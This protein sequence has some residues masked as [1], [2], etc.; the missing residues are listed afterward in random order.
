VAIKTYFDI[1]DIFDIFKLGVSGDGVVLPAYNP[2]FWLNN[3]G[4]SNMDVASTRTS[5]AT[6]PDHEGVYV[7]CGAGEIMP[8]GG[9][10]EQN[11]L[12]DCRD[13]SAWSGADGDVI[14]NAALSSDG[15]MRADLLAKGVGV[16]AYRYKSLPAQG[17]GLLVL[18]VKSQDGAEPN[19]L[20]LRDGGA[21]S[22]WIDVSGKVLG[23]VNHSNAGVEDLG[24][25]WL[26]V[27]IVISNS[28]WAG[29]YLFLADS[30]GSA[31]STNWTAGKGLYFDRMMTQPVQGRTDP[32]PSEFLDSET[33]YGY[34]VNGVKWYSTTNGNTESG[35]VVTE[36][37]GVAIDPVPQVLMQ[38]QRTNSV[39]NSFFSELGGGGADVFASW[40]ET[41][42]GSTVIEQETVDVYPGTTSALKFVMDAS[43]SYCH[44]A[45]T[46]KLDVGDGGQAVMSALVKAGHPSGFMFLVR[47]DDGSGGLP[48]YLSADG[49]S[50]GTTDNFEPSD[51]PITWGKWAHTLPPLSAGR[52]HVYINRILRNVGASVTHRLTAF[53]LEEGLVATTPI[54]TTTAAV[55]RDND[56]IEATDASS[57]MDAEEGIAILSFVPSDDWSNSKASTYIS[58]TGSSV[59]YRTQTT[60]GLRAYDGTSATSV[61]AGNAPGAEVISATIWSAALNSFVIGY[62]FDGG[63]TWD[64]DASPAT[65]SA[66]PIGADL[67][68]GNTISEEYTQ[69]S[70]LTYRGMPPGTTTLTEVQ[71]WIEAEATNEINKREG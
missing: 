8:E 9:R 70:A 61:F 24:D 56:L 49:L 4:L 3:L 18:D 45:Q 62:T 2:A 47:S 40:V 30:N 68:L 35:G 26:R 10:R 15:E 41:A 37:P 19:W 14:T 58:T 34:G 50:W 53:K 6:V 51:L 11:L 64:W 44:L 25:G 1:F 65:F 36:A 20:R 21:I 55:T 63:S 33:D 31:S 16:N 52:T 29:L 69:R 39:V 23:T 60:D 48:E 67:D 13:L 28:S 43:A 22:S 5:T 46:S 12:P 71:D 54:K 59:V 57:F 66:L 42:T 38:P 32:V 27:F 17:E 7:E